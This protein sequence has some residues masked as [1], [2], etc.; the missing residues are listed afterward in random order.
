MFGARSKRLGDLL[1][2]SVVIYERAGPRRAA[3]PQHFSVPYPLG[4]WAQALDLSGLD[5][6]LAL[7]VRQF[8]VRASQLTPE[9]AHQLGEALRARVEQVITPPAPPGT[10]TPWVLTT[11]LAERRRRAELAARPTQPPSS[12]QWPASGSAPGPTPPPPQSRPPSPGGPGFAPP[13]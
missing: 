4:G 12:V 5:D 10:P 2:G 7:A 3:V 9:A 1:A 6:G 13:G 8:V 11:V